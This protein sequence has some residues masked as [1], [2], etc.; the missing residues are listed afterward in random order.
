MVA[1]PLPDSAKIVVIGGGLGGASVAYHLAEL[2]ETDVALIERAELTSGS[3]FHSAGLVGQLRADPTLTRMNQYSVELYRRL[4]DGSEGSTDDPAPG[5]VES[6]GIRL[7]SSAERMEEIRRQIGWA[8]AFGL[9]LQEITASEAQGQFPLLNADGV[10]GGAYL[11]SDGHVDPSQLCHALATHARRAGV[12]IHQ[13][14]RVTGIDTDRGRVTTVRTDRG[15][16]ECET[17]VNCA[18]MFAAEIGRMVDVRIPVV[19]LSHQYLVTEAFLEPRE[20]PLPSMRDPDL[21]VYFRQEVNGL[22]MGGYERDPAPFATDHN[23]YDAIP[24]DF[25]GR[26][27]P[28]DW[29]R[30]EEITTNAQVRVPAMADVGIRSFVNGPEGFTPDNEFCLG[31]TDVD[32]FFVAAG[33]C[34]HGIAGAG[35]VGRVLAEWV[36]AGE[37]SL[38]VWHMDV[39]RFGRHY[40]SPAYTLARTLETYRT[41]YDITHPLHERSAGRPLR[42]P[43]AYGWHREHD[44]E[45]GEKAGWERVNHYRSNATRG[46]EA[47]RPRGWAGR[48]WSPAVGAEHSATREAAVLFDQS[49]FAKIEVSGPDAAEL[50]EWLCANRVARDVGAVTYTQLLNSSGGIEADLTV[51]RWGPDLFWVVTGTAYGSHDLAWLQRHAR[52]RGADVR[53]ADVTGQHCCYC[54][55]GPN[56]RDVLG[57]LTGADLTDDGFGFMSAQHISVGDVPVRAQRVTFTGELGWELYAPTEFGLGLWEALLDAGRDHG[58][59]PGGYHAI[60]SLRLEKGYRVWSR[61]VTPETTPYEAG[62]GFAV[63]LDKPGGFLGRDALV[64]ARKPGPAQRLRCLVMSDPRSVALGNE[65]VR[66]GDEVRGRVT[67]GGYGYTVEK[68]I[69]YGYLPADVEVGTGVAVLVDGEWVA[70]EVVNEPLFDP[71]GER[72]R[73]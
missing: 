45:F 42:T 28:D 62:L 70:A 44:A 9:D 71:K 66:V 15:T 53:I 55:W 52:R 60:E 27:L 8:A 67:S 58:L 50:L 63:R 72:F 10:V 73:G 54:L 41:Y 46:D 2:G 5:W 6:G 68:S 37:P 65:P 14:T 23:T 35:G 49:S 11:A 69:A 18:G 7:A 57:R 51:T 30:L 43:P 34:A 64:E 32:G 36:V 56:S 13:H 31:E 3:T 29:D 26:L 19:P 24:A 4:Q 33:F 61:E 21:L 39:R 59:T 22:V 40:R 17:V 48:L 47:L 12:A 38:D 16:I 1:T 25:N 20:Q